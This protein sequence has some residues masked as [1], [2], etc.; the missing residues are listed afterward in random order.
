L[1]R[2]V[3]ARQVFDSRGFPTIECNLKTDKGIFRAMVPSG[4]STGSHEALE[5]RD[6]GVHY[7]GKG[8]LKAVSNVNNIISRKITGKA[9]NQNEIDQLMISLD[10]TPNKSRLGAN[11]ILSVSMAVCRAGAY[12]SGKPLHDYIGTLA[13]V[14]K[15]FIPVPLL[16]VI[17][18][19]KHAG[20]ENDIQEHMIVPVG[21]KSFSEAMMMSVE[22]YQS[23]KNTLK[24]RFGASATNIAD[25]GGFA[26]DIKGLKERLEIITRAIEQCGYAK[27]VS[28]ALDCAASEF[29]DGEFYHIRE[30]KF[31]PGELA[32][33]YEDL[34][35]VFNIIS[36]EDGMAEDDWDGWAEMTRK[37]G[38]KIQ[39]VGDDLLVTNT[40]RIEDA[41]RKKA[42]NSALIKPNQIGT[43]TETIN[44]V[45]LAHKNKW[46][47]VIS[48]RSGETEDSFI[49]DFVVGV[50]SSQIKTGAPARSERLAKYNQLLRIEDEYRFPYARIR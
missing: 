12:H 38:K 33:Y 1:I 14:K 42:A 44:A 10:G 13:G 20:I 25:E 7:R 17:N 9:L 28:L 40:K 24:K 41:I 43:V 3:K 22:I 6:G 34:C 8:V 21:A 29:F 16:N 48:H 15:K 45:T 18:G 5:L 35:S 39:I 27:K 4:A 30:S 46:S 50:G 36:I 32:D 47:T 37:L 26:P 2:G 19:G 31:S 23:L 49:A 11:A